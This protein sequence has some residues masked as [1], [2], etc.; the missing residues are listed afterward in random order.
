VASSGLALSSLDSSIYKTDGTLQTDRTVT[1]GAKN[2]IFSSTT[3]NF[4]FNPSLTG[5]VGIGIASPAYSL[6]VSASSNPLRLGGLQNGSLSD[7]FLTVSNGVV[8]EVIPTPKGILGTL[9][10]GSDIPGTATSRYYCTGSYITLP[11]GKYM[12]FSYM[13]LDNSLSSNSS[14]GSF[15]LK[16]L[17]ADPSYGIT[18]GASYSPATNATMATADIVGAGKLVSGSINCG[19]PYNL[20]SGFVIINNTSGG[21][22]SYYLWAGWV[23]LTTVNSTSKINLFGGTNYAE[24][25]IVALPVY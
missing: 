5:S 13:T 9:G 18:A 6:D 8:R 11:P 24:D 22:K 1:M 20:L 12:V 25:N 23:Q 17:F 14:P 3:G 21:S 19:Q 10:T 7:S 15:F 2:L 4:I 16:T